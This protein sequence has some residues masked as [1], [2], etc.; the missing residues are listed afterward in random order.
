MLINCSIPSFSLTNSGKMLF[1]DQIN[2][3]DKIIYKENTMDAGVFWIKLKV[4][5][6]HDSRKKILLLLLDDKQ[7][8]FV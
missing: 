2:I 5:Q 8:R 7:C 6:S 3:F 4:M 1:H